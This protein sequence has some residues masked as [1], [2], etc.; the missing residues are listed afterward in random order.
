MRTFISICY[1]SSPL[2]IREVTRSSRACCAPYA[3]TASPLHT[4]CER[5]ERFLPDLFVFVAEPAVPVGNKLAE[6]SVRPLVIARKSSGGLS[7]RFCT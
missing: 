4:W 7:T 1:L 3:H 6:R 2:E 5:I